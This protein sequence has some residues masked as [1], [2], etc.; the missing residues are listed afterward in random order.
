MGSSFTELVWKEFA[1]NK[2]VTIDDLFE[3]LSKNSQID[4]PPIKLRHR[5]RSIL[6]SLHQA[7]KIERVR[8][9]TYKKI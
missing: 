5:I 2:Q 7:H 1:N 3:V 9:S 8:P 4:K 6:Y